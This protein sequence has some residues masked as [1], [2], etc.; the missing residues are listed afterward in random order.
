MSAKYEVGQEVRVF[1]VNGRHH[2]QP[3]GGWKG[4]IVRV[5]R[6]LVSVDFP[7][8][9][10]KAFRIDDQ[11]ANDNYRHQWFRTL[12]EVALIERKDK[13]REVLKSVGLELSLKNG[14]TVEQLEALAEVIGTHAAFTQETA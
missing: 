11:R 10:S 3:E 14:L 4:E 7:G 5:G 12:E 2:G 13:A 8:Y 1:D 9:G 6:K